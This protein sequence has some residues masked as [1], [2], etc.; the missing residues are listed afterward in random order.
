MPDNIMNVVNIT[1]YAKEKPGGSEFGRPMCISF[2]SPKFDGPAGFGGL[3]FR[4]RVENGDVWGVLDAVKREGAIDA[5]ED[6]RYLYMPWPC[7]AVVIHEVDDDLFG[8]P[9]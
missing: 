6:G 1:D 2:F 5:L 3:R 4:V 7:A 9:N 8:E